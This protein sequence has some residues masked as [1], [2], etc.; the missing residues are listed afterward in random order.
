MRTYFLGS[1]GLG[2]SIAFMA[3][4]PWDL[5]AMLPNAMFGVFLSVMIVAGTT[6]IQTEV[7]PSFL[8][9]VNSVWTIAGGIGLAASL[10]VGAL[11][12]EFGLRYVLAGCG[13]ALAVGAISNGTLRASTLRRREVSAAAI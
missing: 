3:A 4:T 7:E 9:R 8:G 11:G 10:P 1:V 6:V 2:L 12:D 5:V 13:L